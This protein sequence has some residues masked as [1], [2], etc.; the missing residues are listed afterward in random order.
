MTTLWIV[1]AVLAFWISLSPLGT[2]WQLE[3]DFQEGLTY[4]GLGIHQVSDMLRNLCIA[5]EID[6]ACLEARQHL[7][8]A[9]QAFAYLSQLDVGNADA[10]ELKALRSRLD[11]A[12][13]QVHLARTQ[14]MSVAPPE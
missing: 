8:A 10:Q 7:L 4:L 13:M 5:A 12:L 11:E 9:N 1:I 2:R 6:G 3:Q 14:L